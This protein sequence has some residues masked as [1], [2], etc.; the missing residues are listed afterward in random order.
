MHKKEFS[1]KKLPKPDP[2]WKETI[3]DIVANYRDESFVLQFLSPKVARQF[4]LFSV[5]LQEG[6]DFVEV[7]GTHDDESF[8][9]VRATLAEQYDLSRSIPQIEVSDVDWHGD[10]TLTLKHI[11]KNNQRIKY[12]DAYATL[13]YIR[14]LWGFSVGIEYVDL[15]GNQLEKVR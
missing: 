10:R 9:K 8:L 3:K 4:K 13:E 1:W 11:S 14:H 12:D 7:N 2:N 5:H 15:D 6:K